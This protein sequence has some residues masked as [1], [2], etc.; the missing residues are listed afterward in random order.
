MDKEFHQ[1]FLLITS[2]LGGITFT[3]L[4]FLIQIKDEYTYAEYLISATALVSLLLVM[5]TLSRLFLAT[6]QDGL[7]EE[8]DL[9]VGLL[10]VAGLIGFLTIIPFMIL[11]FSLIGAITIGIVEI[12]L[13]II[14]MLLSTK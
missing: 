12:V 2:F 9:F 13:F 6:H 11:P 8:Y 10:A 14:W 1:Q 7:H 3:A 5:A 4:I